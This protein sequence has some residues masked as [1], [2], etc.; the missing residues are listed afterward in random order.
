MY[1]GQRKSRVVIEQAVNCDFSLLPQRPYSPVLTPLDYHLFPNMKKPLRGRVFANDE[2][3]KTAILDAPEGFEL[4]FFNEDLKALAK[5]SEKLVR[6][7]D[8]YMDK[9][10][11]LNYE[12]DLASLLLHGWAENLLNTPRSV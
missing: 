9:L 8:D 11:F 7:N 4:Y 10:T 6:V 12:V 3:T 2:E 1:A 5:C